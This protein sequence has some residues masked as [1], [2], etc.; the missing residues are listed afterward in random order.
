[1]KV[2]YAEEAVADIIEAITYLNERNPTAA[3]NSTGISHDASNVTG[4]IDVRI[5]ARRA[6][7]S[8]S[9]ICM[10]GASCWTREPD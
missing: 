10:C 7:G 2:S 8:C 9:G 6:S 3:A 1:L 5:V 4:F